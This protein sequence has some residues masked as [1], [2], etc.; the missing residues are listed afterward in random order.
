MSTGWEV[1]NQNTDLSQSGTVPRESLVKEDV[2]GLSQTGAA[3]C[4]RLMRKWK[5]T[6]LLQKKN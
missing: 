5:G 6:M 4:D 2:T 3:T 1:K